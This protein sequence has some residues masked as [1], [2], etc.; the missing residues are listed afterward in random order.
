MAP[1]RTSAAPSRSA[2]EIQIRWCAAASGQAVISHDHVQVVFKALI[3]VHTLVRAGH[4]ENVLG[5]LCGSKVLGLES[6]VSGHDTA[7]NLN[8]Y[9]VYLDRRIRTYG[10]I[11]YDVIRDKAEKRGALAAPSL[12]DLFRRRAHRR[13]RWHSRLQ[14]S[15]LPLG[16]QGAAPRGDLAA[17]GD[18]HAR[19]VQGATMTRA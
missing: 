12:T 9:A 5:Y 10:A 4:K 16:R 7:Q 8:K 14:P 19:R 11:K 1:S 13:T 3:I 17:K 15:A 2:S 6:V 18:G